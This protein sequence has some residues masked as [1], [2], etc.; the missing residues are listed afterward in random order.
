MESILREDDMII[1]ACRYSKI[2]TQCPILCNLE[3][4][5]TLNIRLPES[6]NGYRLYDIL[7]IS[8]TPNKTVSFEGVEYGC[9]RPWVD[10]PWDNLDRSCGYHIYKLSFMNNGINKYKQFYIGYII[11]DN[12]PHKDY[13]YMKD[14]YNSLESE[15]SG[16]Y[17]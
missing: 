12:D 14:R 4:E 7:D 5:G 6:L 15:T 2:N 13:I 11:H 8:K 10:I 1:N 17:M 3:A 16:I 9:C